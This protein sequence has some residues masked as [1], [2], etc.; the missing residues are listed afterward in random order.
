MT[1]RIMFL[2][3]NRTALVLIDARDTATLTRWQ[4]DYDTTQ[5]LLRGASPF[6]SVAEQKYIES[7]Y[8]NQNNM[9]LGI[10]HKADQCLIGMTGLH[11]IDQINAHA[12]FGIFI[13][14]PKYRSQGLGT[15]ILTRLCTFAFN[16][17]N[18]R[19]IRLNVISS[20]ERAIAT[21]MRCGFKEIGRYV[22][23]HFHNGAWVDEIIMTRER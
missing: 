20:N 8:T 13:G 2:E 19:T 23:G 7:A 12:T 9:P 15:E 16:R 5:W 21:Y 18:L 10:W 17:R 14:I 6:S 1:E 4:N 3:T 22:N 11:K